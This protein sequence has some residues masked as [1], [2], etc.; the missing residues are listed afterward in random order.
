MRCLL[1]QL[2]HAAVKKQGCR[3]QIIFRRWLPRMGYKKAIWAIAHR[4]CRLIWKVLHDGVR[5]IEKGFEPNP[6]AL[7]D[8]RRRLIAELRQLGYQVELLPL[9]PRPAV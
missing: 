6:K 1:N 4:L 9:D 8:R 3:L 7:R 2:A 5:Y